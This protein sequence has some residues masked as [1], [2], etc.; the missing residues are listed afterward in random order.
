MKKAVGILLIC[1]IALNIALNGATALAEETVTVTVDGVKVDFDQPPIIVEGRTLVPIRAVAERIEADVRWNPNTRTTTIL[2]KNVGVA[3]QIGYQYMT[4]RNL[5]TGDE[6][7]VTL[8]VPPQIYN[9]RT[10]LPIRIIMEM[11]G[12][13]VE[14][15]YISKTVII[16]TE[17]YASKT[18]VI[19][20]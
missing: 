19:G 1:I 17:D 4:V 13:N 20:E 14:W 2:H 7:V 18:I 3:L 15:D 9:N 12:C 5:S 6:R 11:F 10:L 8:D 16:T